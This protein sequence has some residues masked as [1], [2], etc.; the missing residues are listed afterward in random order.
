MNLIWDYAYDESILCLLRGNHIAQWI[1]SN[2]DLL[3]NLL[4]III[5]FQ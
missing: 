5:S 4:I 1:S 3:I 2:S